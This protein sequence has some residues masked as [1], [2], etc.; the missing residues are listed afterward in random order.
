MI[1]TIEMGINEMAMILKKN[2]PLLRL[3]KSY[4]VHKREKKNLFVSKMRKKKVSKYF[5]C[6][7]KIGCL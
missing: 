5:I 4:F 2:I 1:M 6:D 3:L 7:S